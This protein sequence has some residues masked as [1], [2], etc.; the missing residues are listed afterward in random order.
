VA[1]APHPSP[2][3]YPR[4]DPTT[5]RGNSDR[6]VE[7]MRLAGQPTRGGGALAGGGTGGSAAT[8]LTASAPR[9]PRV[10]PSR[11][12]SDRVV[13]SVGLRRSDEPAEEGGVSEPLPPPLQADSHVSLPDGRA[14]PRDRP[15][16]VG[17]GTFEVDLAR[18]PQAI[19]ELED[20][21]RELGE[22]RREAE[23]LGR[24]LPPTNDQV[25]RDAADLLQA[26]AVGGTGSFVQALDSGIAQINDMIVGLRQAMSRYGTTDEEA[27]AAVGQL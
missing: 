18:A 5:G 11:P 10:L 6:I 7:A 14:G 24:I 26:A 8:V 23:Q 15:P 16:A 13:A 25:S 19:R 4:V 22:I 9:H 12:R 3:A 20:A 2:L 27:G 21:A 17:G 1:T